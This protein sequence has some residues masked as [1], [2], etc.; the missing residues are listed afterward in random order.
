MSVR[1][2]LAERLEAGSTVTGVWIQ[3]G[4]PRIVEALGTTAI[5][6]VGIDMEHTPVTFE[7]LESL[8]RAAERAG[9]E[10]MVRVPGVEYA[11]MR[12]IQ[13]A[14]DLGAA[15]VIVPRVESRADIS[16]VLD[17]STFPPDGNRGVAGSIRANEYGDRFDE[18]VSSI[19]DEVVLAV[20][21]ET[22]RGVAHADE[23]LSTPGVDVGFVGENDL[24]AALGTPGRTE[25]PEVREAVTAVREAADEHDVV[26]GIAARD[27]DQ[28]EAR[29]RDGFRF[30]L[31]GSDLTF[32]RHGVRS[33]HPE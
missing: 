12:A 23:I 32:V 26:A 14:L 15:G 25:A 10:T 6:W 20:Q 7:R 4:S 2:G 16:A 1:D 24:S 5:D 33:V 13:Q 8:L 29:S 19:D 9:L 11:S 22:P 21:L 3:S 27:R 31:L 17:A 30:L 28:F 18:Y